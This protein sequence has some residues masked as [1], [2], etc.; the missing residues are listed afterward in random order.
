LAVCDHPYTL[1]E[2]LPRAEF[3]FPE[4]EEVLND[5]ELLVESSAK[6]KFVRKKLREI[7]K[8]REKV[9]LFS[10]PRM[11]QTFLAHLVEI[12]HGFKPEIING[13]VAAYDRQGAVDEFNHSDGFN[14]IILSTQAAGV[15]LNVTG[16]NHV[17]HV[18]REWN[19]AKE[20]QATDRAYRIGQT[21]DVHVYLP[22]AT[23]SGDDRESLDTKLDRVIASKKHLAER[24]IRPSGSIRISKDDFGDIFSA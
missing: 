17:I 11:L 22:I 2:T 15:G 3:P 23:Y 18:H 14:V 9:I 13:D 5:E 24:V 4:L 8:D 16:A 1:S 12:D 7:A 6:M 10:T 21:R 19:P 20:N